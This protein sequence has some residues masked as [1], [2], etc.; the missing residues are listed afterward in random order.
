MFNR[1]YRDGPVVA[2]NSQFQVRIYLFPREGGAWHA[3]I[4]RRSDGMDCK[5]GL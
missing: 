3:R 5:I 2:E 4:V 1:V